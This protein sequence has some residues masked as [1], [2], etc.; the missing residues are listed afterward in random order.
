[1][2][3]CPTPP[4]L[5]PESF[6][7]LIIL[8]PTPGDGPSPFN[9]LNTPMTPSLP[10]NGLINGLA[11]DTLGAKETI[12]E[13]RRKRVRNVTQDLSFVSIMLNEKQDLFFWVVLLNSVLNCIAEIA[14]LRYPIYR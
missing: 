4:E 2:Y 3:L 11:S 1:M 5:G 7:P 8:C 9:V 13:T 14:S 6:I 10:C 12:K